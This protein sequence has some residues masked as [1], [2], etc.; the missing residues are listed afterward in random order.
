MLCL[1]ES[2]L[3]PRRK[4]GQWFDNMHPCQCSCAR[5]SWLSTWFLLLCRRLQLEAE[6]ASWCALHSVGQNY[7]LRAGPLLSE[8][9][10]LHWLEELTLVQTIGRPWW[11]GPIPEAWG[12]PRSFPRLKK[13]VCSTA[14]SAM[15][16]YAAAPGH[17]RPCP[18]IGRHL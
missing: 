8:L 9:A 7:S 1:C 16:Q 15:S 6:D 11:A 3:P 12:Q 10:Q 5:A 18:P 14:G 2:R 17:V 4:C 13:W